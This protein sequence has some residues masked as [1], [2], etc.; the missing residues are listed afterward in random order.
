MGLAFHEVVLAYLDQPDAISSLEQFAYVLAFGT[1]GL[2]FMITATP[3]SH[4]WFSSIAGLS[5]TLAALGENALW[6]VIFLPAL[7]VMESWYQGI[8]VHSHLTR[9]VT[10][11]VLVY[12]MIT[13][14][15][16]VTGVISGLITGLYISVTATF[17]GFLMQTLWLRHRSQPARGQLPIPLAQPEKTKSLSGF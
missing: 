17:L 1:S 10:E 5:P 12:L 4:I 9:A 16:L 8:L 11:S 3:L 15:V 14:S 6:L 13:T 2:L 7:T